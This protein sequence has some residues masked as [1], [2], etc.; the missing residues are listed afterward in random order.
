MF[1]YLISPRGAWILLGFFS[2]RG[3]FRS[4]KLRVLSAWM[5]AAWSPSNGVTFPEQPASL[6][7]FGS[8][9]H[10]PRWKVCTGLN[11]GFF[12]ASWLSTCGAFTL[13]GAMAN[14][15][16]L[17]I[18][19]KRPL[20]LPLLS[21]DMSPW[22]QEMPKGALG[23][24]MTNKVNAVF[25]AACLRVTS[26]IWLPT[27]VERICTLADAPSRQS[28]ATADSERTISKWGCA[29]LAMATPASSTPT[30]SATPKM[31]HNR[32]KFLLLTSSRSFP[33]P[34]LL[35]RFALFLGAV[36]IDTAPRENVEGGR[37]S[38]SHCVTLLARF[39]IA[40]HR[41]IQRLR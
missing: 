18:P 15:S 7:S 31:S 28:L 33:R 8:A 25:L 4:G 6:A 37:M 13:P 36:S 22:Y 24:W 1:T 26:M 16:S 17:K 29:L 3:P 21:V 11:L 5:P 34:M 41:Q 27:G 20:P 30:S 32:A 12:S 10:N 40:L 38:T 35:G 39:G 2:P 23:C 9:N 14:T 19:M